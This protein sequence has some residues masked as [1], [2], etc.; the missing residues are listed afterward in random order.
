MRRILCLFILIFVVALSGCGDKKKEV[1]TNNSQTTKE[2]KRDEN[3]VVG[4]LDKMIEEEKYH[5]EIFEFVDE[6]IESVSKE[7]ADEIIEKLIGYR[8]TYIK[9]VFED[10]YNAKSFQERLLRLNENGQSVIFNSTYDKTGDVMIDRFIAK[11]ESRGCKPVSDEGEIY[12]VDELHWIDKYNEYISEEMKSYISIKQKLVEKKDVSDA[13]LLISF[14]ELYDRIGLIEEFIKNYLNSKHKEEMVRKYEFYLRM[15]FYGLDNTPTFEYNDEKINKEALK[16]YKEKYLNGEDSITKRI[17]LVYLPLLEKNEYTFSGEIE[18]FLDG[19]FTSKEGK[20][21]FED[22]DFKGG[23]GLFRKGQF[24]DYNSLMKMGNSKRKELGISKEEINHI[25]D[26]AKYGEN[27]VLYKRFEEG[28]LKITSLNRLENREDLSK[29]IEVKEHAKITSFGDHIYFIKTV[30]SGESAKKVLVKY[31]Y[32]GNKDEIYSQNNFVYT[33]AP[34][35]DYGAVNSNETIVLMKNNGNVVKRYK[36]IFKLEDEN[37][38]VEFVGWKDNILWLEKGAPGVIGD[39]FYKIDGDNLKVNEYDTSSLSLNSEYDL[40]MNTEK[41]VYSDYPLMFAVDS[42]E[43]FRKANKPV[44]IY[45]YDLNSKE[46]KLINTI[47]GKEA[48]PVWIDDETIEYNDPNGYRSTYHV[49][50]E[51]NVVELDESGKNAI[52]EFHPILFVFKDKD[53]VFSK[54]RVLGGSKDGNWYSIYDF[55]M[56]TDFIEEDYVDTQL[57]RGREQYKF[58]FKGE[59]IGKVMGDSPTLYIS[60]ASGESILSVKIPTIIENR[61]DFII[62]INGEWT[63]IP[64]NIEELDIYKSYLVDLDNDGEKEKIYIEEVSLTSNDGEKAKKLQL[65]I[66][67]NGNPLFV[68]YIILDIVYSTE[69]K[70]Y[71][72]DLNG[73]SKIEI[74]TVAR[75]HNMNIS[76]YELDNLRIKKILNFYDGD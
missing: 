47:R 58:Y 53:G 11:L 20:Y 33:I 76:V 66:E 2:V 59:E 6:N 17:L 35:E 63:G 3:T 55:K 48:E 23:Y 13:A 22:T 28:M 75:G 51:Y 68:E 38:F 26:I 57:V 71:F 61:G 65:Y 70:I 5:D 24:Y 50:N 19:L 37:E 39:V 46:N 49:E 27:K 64:R 9:I 32:K 34:N 7:E 67:K 41:L 44:N 21:L 43:D 14:N 56:P 4:Q 45:L 15:Y 29:E 18:H 52:N 74:I 10:G 8:Q 31:D 36:E 72:A 42:A 54:A 69:Y 30:G 60:Q 1:S 25:K 62:G 12:F 16:S 40:N 73:D